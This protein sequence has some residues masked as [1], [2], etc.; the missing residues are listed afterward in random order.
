M[1][2]EELKED[3]SIMSYLSQTETDSSPKDCE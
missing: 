2:K 1:N 3:E